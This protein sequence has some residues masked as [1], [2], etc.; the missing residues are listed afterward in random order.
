MSITRP[1]VSPPYQS[2]MPDMSSFILYLIRYCLTALSHLCSLFGLRSS[3]LL[4]NL[5][6]AGIFGRFDLGFGSAMVAVSGSG[7]GGGGG[8]GLSGG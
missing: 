1:S 7:G 4:L 5:L 2:T 6:G 3:P 8:P